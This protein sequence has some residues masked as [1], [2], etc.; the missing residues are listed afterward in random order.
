MVVL[1]ENHCRSVI[2]V[3]GPRSLD[4][5]RVSWNA[6]SYHRLTSFSLK[7]VNLLAF[8]SHLI[9]AS[10]SNSVVTLNLSLICKFIHMR[11]LVS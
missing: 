10:R 7:S 3:V 4:I 2:R 11:R 6:L 8:G 1:I 5:S 9:W